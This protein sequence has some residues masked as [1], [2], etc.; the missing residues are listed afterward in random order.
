MRISGLP[1]TVGSYLSAGSVGLC[2][3]ISLT[4][5]N[6][7]SVYSLA[8]EARLSLVQNPVGGGTATGIPMDTAAGPLVISISYTV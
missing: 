6:F 5:S 1:F 8:A 7:M 2:D 4:A 3:G